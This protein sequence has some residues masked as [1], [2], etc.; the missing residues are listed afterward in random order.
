MADLVFAFLAHD[1]LNSV[2][3]WL[4]GQGWTLQVGAPLEK[5]C[6]EPQPSLGPV[7]REAGG[8]ADSFQDAQ[9]ADDV[10][11][12]LTHFRHAVPPRARPPSRMHSEREEQTATA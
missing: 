9:Y 10:A 6:L 7:P 1:V 2:R 3:Q 5:G 12:K 8:Q 4:R 11:V